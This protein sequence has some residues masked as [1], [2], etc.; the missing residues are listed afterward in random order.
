MS[1]WALHQVETKHRRRTPTLASTFLQDPSFGAAATQRPTS[2]KKGVLKKSVYVVNPWTREV[3]ESAQAEDMSRTQVLSPRQREMRV[4]EDDGLEKEV[5]NCQWEWGWNKDCVLHGAVARKNAKMATRHAA[6]DDGGE[7]SD[8]KWEEVESEMQQHARIHGFEVQRHAGVGS[9]T[10]GVTRDERGWWV[11]KG[12][13][14]DGERKVGFVNN[15][16]PDD[17]EDEREEK[18]MASGDVETDILGKP[19]SKQQRASGY[20]KTDRIIGKKNV[21]DDNINRARERLE[22]STAAVKVIEDDLK[23]ATGVLRDIGRESAGGGGG[24]GA[25]GGPGSDRR[26]EQLR[27]LADEA[28]S[29]QRPNVMPDHSKAR[30]ATSSSSPPPSKQHMP[31]HVR[32]SYEHEI[33]KIGYATRV[34]RN[35][36]NEN[37]ASMMGQR[38]FGRR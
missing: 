1:L 22:E 7:S 17:Y 33:D 37:A 19:I 15:E 12:E 16:L 34:E 27:K 28:N 29:W 35:V 18:K 2:P 5:C 11:D 36:R 30:Q 13:M 24:G 3:G 38:V 23:A 31:M 21:F 25:G 20:W 32:A 8:F 9:A 6:V 26:R 4:R 14:H 10:A